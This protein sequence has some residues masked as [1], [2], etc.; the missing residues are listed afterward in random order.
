MIFEASC[1]VF[2]GIERKGIIK[3]QICLPLVDLICI[4]DDGGI[5]FLAET[6]VQHRNR[7][8][9]GFNHDLFKHISRSYRFQLVFITQKHDA[10]ARLDMGKK[11]RTARYMSIILDSSTMI[12]SSGSRKSSFHSS[13]P[14]SPFI[15][16]ALWM[17][18]AG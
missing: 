15:P 1:A 17:V 10:G 6:F 13:S 16:T 18:M 11:L 2:A 7:D 14:S 12:R 9:A 4:L 5:P 3:N 8:Y